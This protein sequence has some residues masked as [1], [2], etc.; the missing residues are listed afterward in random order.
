MNNALVLPHTEGFTKVFWDFYANDCHKN[1]YPCEIVKSLN[2]EC[3][4]F[5]LQ[6]KG[7]R[8]MA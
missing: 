6:I 2:R 4:T 8:E 7:K 3:L 1:L 5:V